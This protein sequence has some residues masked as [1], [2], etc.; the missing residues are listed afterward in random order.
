MGNG[1]HDDDP[2]WNTLKAADYLGLM[3]KTLERMRATG[4]GPP[5]RK[6]GRYV[7][8]TRAE[9]DA[10]SRA[11]SHRAAEF[12]AHKPRNIEAPPGPKSG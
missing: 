8:Y 4:D 7:R 11:R 2:F 9:L 5:Y 10:W 6:H 3:P 12:H 1:T